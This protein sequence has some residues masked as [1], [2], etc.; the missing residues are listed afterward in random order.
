MAGVTRLDKKGMKHI[1]VSYLLPWKPVYASDGSITGLQE[2]EDR[3]DIGYAIVNLKK[4]YPP[5]VLIGLYNA[6]LFPASTFEHV[7]ALFKTQLDAHLVH[8]EA[9][10]TIK[11]HN[12]YAN[13]ELRRILYYQLID[14]PVNLKFDSHR[15]WSGFVALQQA[16][17][18]K[19]VEIYEPG[20]L[21]IYGYYIRHLASYFL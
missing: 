18:D 9:Q 5:A 17:A 21:S 7:S 1:L 19:I 11:M 8:V 3:T 4:L 15:L 14:R 16:F 6:D 10:D 12:Q 20:D 2:Y 13:E